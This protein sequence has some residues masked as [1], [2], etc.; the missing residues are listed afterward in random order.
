MD[1]SASLQRFIDKV[2]RVM[3]LT[4]LT[5][6][7]IHEF[8]KKI[9][10]SKPEYKIYYNCVGIVRGPSTEEMEELFQEHLQNGKS[11]L[12]ESTATYYN[13]GMIDLNILEKITTR[14]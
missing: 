11:M 4:E 3:H 8:I 9:V 10:I 2:K 1:K 14:I 7:I 12:V 5:L 6:E 13:K